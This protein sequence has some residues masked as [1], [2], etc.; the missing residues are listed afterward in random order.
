[1]IKSLKYLAE[2]SKP[3][4]NNG[5]IFKERRKTV[6]RIKPEST[7]LVAMFLCIP[8]SQSDSV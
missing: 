2:F 4:K 6:S 3:Q 5:L 8:K 7:N 1:V